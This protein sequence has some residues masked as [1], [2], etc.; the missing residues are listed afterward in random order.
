LKGIGTM[1][2]YDVFLINPPSSRMKEKYEHLGLA[3]I[4]AFLRKYD[5]NTKIIDIPLYDLYPNDVIYEIKSDK[6]K[7]IGVSIPFQDSASEALEFVKSIREAG[8]K[9]HISIGGIY[10]TFSY[11]EILS[12][13]PQIDTVVVGEGEITFLELA[14][15]V[16]SD[17]DWK[18]ISG[19]AYRD[20]G[21]LR[22]NDKRP[23]ID[24]LDSMPYP[25]RDTLPIVILKSGF[26]SMLT[27]RGCYGRCSFCSVG[28]FFSQFGQ[29]YRQRSVENVIDEIR[30]LYEKYNVRNLFFNDA[31]FI[32]GKGK[33]YERAYKLAEEL[34][35]SGMDL[36]FS[37]QCRVNDVEQEL[38][39]M[40]KK[41]GL[42]R[43]F[44]G[45]ES[46]SQTVLDRFKKDVSVEDNIKALKILNELEL[47]ISMGFIMF[48]PHINYK[49]LSENISFINNAVKLVGKE[50]LDY[51]PVSRLLP[52][53]G[54]E[55]EREMKE[56]GKYKGNTL[57]YSYEFDDKTIGFIYNL[58]HSVYNLVGNLKS[59]FKGNSESNTKW[60]KR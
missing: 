37:I 19:I 8:Y 4:A 17:E 9:G 34:I 57:N 32:G 27:S 13:C 25:E 58:S 47:Y 7:L 31:E 26:A 60:M 21:T 12:V 43:V 38:F 41:A 42:R 29:K 14:R 40:L 39:T 5:I 2:Q 52:L 6:P 56:A 3:Y 50:R 23:L 20:D 48:D 30:I 1:E 15:K 10:P 51:Y 53:A 33:N 11:D 36:H 18:N 28:P 35:K 45:V 54:T 49:E 44:L 46:G 16:L 55:V 22:L 59:R 24:D